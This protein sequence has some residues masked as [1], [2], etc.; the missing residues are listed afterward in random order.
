[1]ARQADDAEDL[2]RA[3]RSPNGRRRRL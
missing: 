1:M 2:S 3:R